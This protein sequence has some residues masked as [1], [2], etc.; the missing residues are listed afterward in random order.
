MA[1]KPLKKPNRAPKAMGLSTKTQKVGLLWHF[2][3]NFEM[4]ECA[5]SQIPKVPWKGKGSSVFIRIARHKVQ[6]P[7]N[8][9]KIYAPF[10]DIFLIFSFAI[11]GE[12]A[13]KRTHFSSPDWCAGSVVVQL[14]LPSYKQ[15]KLDTCNWTPTW[16]PFNYVSNRGMWRTNHN[17]AFCYGLSKLMYLKFTVWC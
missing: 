4:F 5:F 7:I 17:R 6:L 9:E 3:Q 13:I 16:S 15:F 10:R 11:S 2:C 12:T 1:N 14:Q 8:R